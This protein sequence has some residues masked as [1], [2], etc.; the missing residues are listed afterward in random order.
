MDGAALLV[1]LFLIFV[2]AGAVKGVVGLGLP[3]VSLALLVLVVDL[4]RAM[5][6][7]LLP[8]LATNLWQGLAGGGLAP[9]A[10]RLGPL[11][12]AGAVCAWA[13]AGVLAR[14]EAAPLLALLG[15]SLALYA[16]V[17]LSDWHPPAPGRRET[18]VGVLL[19]AVT[20]VLT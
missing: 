20:G 18:L 9:V 13:A 10:R 4:P 8:S 19:G 16:A 3:T 17:G 15:V 1:P 2:L 11:M 5:T 7:M 14:A 6:L 12:A